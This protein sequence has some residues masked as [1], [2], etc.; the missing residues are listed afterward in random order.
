MRVFSITAMLVCL[1]VTGCGPKKSLLQDTVPPDASL[2]KAASG[3]H[4][5]EAKPAALKQ[6]DAFYVGPVTVLTGDSGRLTPSNDREMEDLGRQF[7][8]RIIRSLGSRHTMFPHPANNVAIIDVTL[9]NMWSNRAL[10]NLRPGILIPNS[11]DG[12]A[13]MQT[14]FI[15]SVSKKP[16][17][18]VWDSRSG[19]RKGYLTGLTTWGGTKSTFDEW[20]M[21]LNKN[22]RKSQTESLMR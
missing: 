2:Q 17:L 5:W 11:L 7:R 10:A 3:V 8:Q 9:T 18:K 21:L 4:I 1:L 6:Y 20:A 15:D 16:V 22:M 12:G 13:T 19:E 14:V